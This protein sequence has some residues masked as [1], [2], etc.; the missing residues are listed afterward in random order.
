MNEFSFATVEKFDDHINDSVRGYSNLIDDVIHMSQYFLEPN[1]RMI[2]IG[3]STGKMIHEMSNVNK[4]VITNI[5]Y[6]GIESEPNM[7]ENQ[8]EDK[9]IKYFNDDVREY[10][11][12][13]NA[14]LITSIFT[15]QFI[16]KCDRQKIVTD[17]YRALN[18]GGAFIFAEKVYSKN[19]RIQD[20]LTFM[21][22]DFKRQKFDAESILD[23][24]RSLRHMLRPMTEHDLV[25]LN[26]L[27]QKAGFSVIEPFWRNFNFV[28]Y[29]AIK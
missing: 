24:E 17:V 8:I 20:M 7:I 3:C 25:G 21:Y 9:S 28:G 19:S 1:T 23:K 18:P 26:S 27:V 15:L 29:V 6:T 16:N 5:S 12:W 10:K 14:S 22:Y 4:D 13:R 2:D 11:N